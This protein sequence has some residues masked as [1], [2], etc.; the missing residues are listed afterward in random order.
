MSTKRKK[1]SRRPAPAAPARLFHYTARAYVPNI[2]AEGL[3]VTSPSLC[4]ATAAETAQLERTGEMIEAGCPG[5]VWFASDGPGQGDDHGL[6]S[7]KRQVRIE[8]DPALTFEKWSKWAR[9]QPRHEEDYLRALNR[10]GGG[11]A[12]T[13]YVHVGHIF[14][15][16]IVEVL[17]LDTGEV[18]YSRSAVLAA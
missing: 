11:K 9:K 10:R 13:W 18:L 7:I 5:V 6:P 1:P 16:R 3:R 8:V 2:L 12:S 15:R 4:R 14:P 17:D